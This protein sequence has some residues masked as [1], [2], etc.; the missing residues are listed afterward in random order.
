VQI[1]H[2]IVTFCLY[3]TVN[4]ELLLIN[5]A[6]YSSDYHRY[7]N[8]I[9]LSSRVLVQI[10]IIRQEFPKF[11]GFSRFICFSKQS[12]TATFSGIDKSSLHLKNLFL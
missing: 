12:I 5:T 8:Y 2:N 9:T 4:P 3:R 11:C 6:S 10:L 1:T 7:I